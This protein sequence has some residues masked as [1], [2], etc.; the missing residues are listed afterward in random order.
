M[1]DAINGH[2]LR[3]VRQGIAQ[4]A[5]AAPARFR[6]KLPG[7][8]TEVFLGVILSEQN[9]AAHADALQAVTACGGKNLGSAELDQRTHRKALQRSFSTNP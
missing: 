8:E 7:W 1:T 9:S 5:A 3:P 6:M 4:L 2:G